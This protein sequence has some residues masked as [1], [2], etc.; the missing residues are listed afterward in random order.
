MRLSRRRFLGD[1]APGLL[2]P[3]IACG[4]RDETRVAAREGTLSGGETGEAWPAPATDGAPFLHGIAS[5]DPNADAVILWTRVTPEAGRADATVVEW[6]IAADKGMRDVVARGVASADAARDYTV[7]VDAT[8]LS[9]D[10]TYYYQFRAG[11]RTSPVGRTKTLPSGS[12]AR[13]R[14]A[15]ASCSNYPAGFFNAYAAIARADLDLVLHLGDY[16]YEYAN[17]TFGDGAALGR[18]PEPA[19]ELITLE[20]YR[21]RHGQYKRDPD[22]RELHRQHPMICIWDD[23]EVANDAYSGGAQNHQSNEGDFELRKLA[24]AQAYREWMPRRDQGRASIYEA[25]PC[26]DLLDLVM[27]DTRLEGRE[28]VGRPCDL[29]LFA[30]PERQL[31]GATQE[32]WLAERL[33]ASR[34]RGARWRLIGQQVLFAPLQRLGGCVQDPDMW[35]GYAA[36]RERVLAML[37]RESIDNVVMLTGD[38]HASYAIDVAR[39]PFDVSEYDAATGRGSRLV[40]LVAP[41]VSSPGHRGDAALILSEHPHMKFTDQVRQGYILVDVTHER[42]QAEWYFV[43]TVLERTADVELGAVFQT[44]SGAPHLVRAERASSARADAPELAP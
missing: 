21:E 40:E 33:S 8:G 17:G 2:S 6:R 34:A 27:L 14:L 25:F 20:D 30:E 42:V 7:H 16:I 24:A 43:A 12:T 36:G 38:A 26:G 22:L 23:H 1:L 3:L 44:F 19:R 29:A 28:A 41:G 15:V 32:A 13:M 10:T 18:M 4:G 11:E 39:N 37:E 5:G 9:S 35:D 31:L